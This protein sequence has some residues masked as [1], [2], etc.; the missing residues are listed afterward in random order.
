MQRLRTGTSGSAPATQ[1]RTQPEAGARRDRP[2]GQRARAPRQRPRDRLGHLS[3]RTRR[4]PASRPIHR[5]RVDIVTVRRRPTGR[6]SPKPRRDRGRLRV[7]KDEIART[8]RYV[9]R[10]L[11]LRSS[12]QTPRATSPVRLRSGPLRTRPSVGPPEACST[13]QKEQGT[14][15]QIAWL[16]SLPPPSTPP[17]RCSS[18]KV[19]QSEV[20]DVA[21]ISEVTIRNRYHELLEAED[22]A[23]LN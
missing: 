12:P 16:G 8:Y 2:H 20:S 18:T 15:R 3:A 23:T 10:E 9:V 7:E 19:T 1:R 11:K 6:N 13:R 4:G 21:N 22:G 14:T 17:V 5:G